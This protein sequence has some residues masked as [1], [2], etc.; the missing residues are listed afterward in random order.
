MHASIGPRMPI[1]GTTT[2]DA[3]MTRGLASAPPT[4][5]FQATRPTQAAAVE[6]LK[7]LFEIETITVPRPGKASKKKRTKQTKKIKI[8]IKAVQVKKFHVF[9]ECF[10]FYVFVVW[11]FGF[12]KSGLLFFCWSGDTFF[13]SLFAIYCDLLI[14]ACGV[15]CVFLCFQTDLAATAQTQL[16]K[17]A[18]NTKLKNERGSVL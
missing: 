10:V 11:G 4:M 13:M 8:K 6:T 16:N 2:N 7:N 1:Q 17:T 18:A 12:Y 15:I 5:P 14:Y 3:V 9:I